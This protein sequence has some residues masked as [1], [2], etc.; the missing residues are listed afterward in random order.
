MELKVEAKSFITDKIEEN[1][2]LL[3]EMFQKGQNPEEI[4][5]KYNSR[6]VSFKLK[7]PSYVFS[8]S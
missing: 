2:L 5:K 3:F 4:V 7:F 8:K 1:I 6:G